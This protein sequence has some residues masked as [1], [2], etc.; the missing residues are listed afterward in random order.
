MSSVYR[1]HLAGALPNDLPAP[2]ASAAHDSLGA[3][4]QVSGRI[5]PA[6]AQLA[7]VARDAF[8]TAMSGASLVAA[9]VAAL[10]AIAAWRYLPARAV[11]EV[12]VEDRGEPTA[13][14]WYIRACACSY[15][16][17]RTCECL[18]Q[19]CDDEPAS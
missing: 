15:A 3:A 16:Y 14:P 6:G 17:G 19:C 9:C 10:A 2:I 4:L 7:T 18:S 13:V 12:T 11:G 8:V 1:S 5:G